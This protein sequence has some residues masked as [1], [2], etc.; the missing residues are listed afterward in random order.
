MNCYPCLYNIFIAEI[1]IN[2]K[3]KFKKPQD[4]RILYI[5]LL[6]PKN[7]EAVEIDAEFSEFLYPFFSCQCVV[8]FLQKQLLL[9]LYSANKIFPFVFSKKKVQWFYLILIYFRRFLMSSS[10]TKENPSA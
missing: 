1:F 4:K 9:A 10:K 7:I 6:S 8:S 2:E 5:D 3:N